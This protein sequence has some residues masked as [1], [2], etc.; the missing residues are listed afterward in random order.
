M[1]V[2]LKKKFTA[3]FNTEPLVFQSPGRVN[4]IG[5]HTDYNKGFVLPAAIDKASYVAISKREDEQVILYS[6]LFNKQVACD[7][8]NIKPM[9]EGW[10]NYILGVVNELRKSTPKLTGFNLV[11]DGDVPMGAGLSSS[12][13]VECAVAF[14]LNHL[15]ELNLSP[16][17]MA[18]VSQK[19]EHN[20]AGVMCGIMDQFA[21]VFGKKD[22]AIQLDCRSMAY[23]YI[24][25]DL[26]GYK[27]LLLN[28]NVEHALAS[29]EYNIRRQQ[30]E[31]GVEIVRNHQENVESLR[32]VTMQMLDSYVKE[33][34]D[35]VYTKCKYVVEENDRLLAAVHALQN[36]DLVT[37]GKKMFASHDGLSNM[38]KVSCP[39]LDYLVEYVRSNSA[40]AGA[41]MMGGG[42][43]GCTINLVK[44]ESI[45][46]LLAI[47]CTD[48]QKNMG[49]DLSFYIA[50]TANGSSEV[51]G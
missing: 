12:A 26:K 45:E 35:E 40:V 31:Q 24:P 38:Y 46:E 23:D 19:A 30:C 47:I 33:W 7:L 42:F 28:T 27:I 17:E 9:Q 16:I 15:F 4:I 11:L 43:G 49:R 41:R 3:L 37:L 36:G 34:D 50:E 48:Y 5:E 21:S 32:D 25:L 29:T 1:I 44:E 13:S 6:S 39:E 20:F 8:N 2:Q 10:P 22:H 14:G 51:L 18:L